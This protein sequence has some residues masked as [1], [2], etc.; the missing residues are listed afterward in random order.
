M[1]AQIAPIMY[2]LGER[3]LCY[4]PDP[5]KVSK[6]FPAIVNQVCVLP[7]SLNLLS[8]LQYVLPPGGSRAEE[9]PRALL[10]VGASLG[11]VAL[12]L[13]I[14]YITVEALTTPTGEGLST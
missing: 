5:G 7:A 10:W 12:M 14:Q 4:E 3:V 11:Q 13:Y 2:R 8:I 1:L 6:I 9:L